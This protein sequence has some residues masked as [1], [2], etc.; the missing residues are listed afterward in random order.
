M[1]TDSIAYASMLVSKEA[2][3]WA[4][5]SMIAATIAA[6][7]SL[8]TSI[9][10]GIAALVAYR[11]MNAWRQQEDLKEKKLLKTAL[12]KYRHVLVRM[13]NRMCESNEKWKELSRQLE[14][15]A[16]EIYYPLVNLERDLHEG[17][18]GGKVY[19]LLNLH[20]DYLECGAENKDV[21]AC[22]NDLLQMRIID[23]KNKPS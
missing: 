16:N 18:I 15:A 7:A 22:L 3:N 20:Y 8:V 12:V 2:A 5:W 13:P 4:F 11:T 6:V 23:I 17:L 14:D 1:D 21:S 10:T 19:E 9:V